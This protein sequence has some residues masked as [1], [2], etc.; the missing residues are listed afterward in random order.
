[1]NASTVKILQSALNIMKTADVRPGNNVILLGDTYSDPVIIEALQNAAFS[2]D[3]EVSVVSGTE[4]PH[5]G[6]AFGKSFMNSP[7][8]PILDALRSADLIVELHPVMSV[9]WRPFFRAIGEAKGRAT[10]TVLQFGDRELMS[11]ELCTYPIELI[12]TIVRKVREF[13]R[14]GGTVRVTTPAGTD[15]TANYED[16]M[17]GG[18]MSNGDPTPGPLLPGQTV[19][20]PH[21]VCGFV[22]SPVSGKAVCE[23]FRGFAGDLKEPIVLT[24]DKG[25]VLN[26]DGGD[27]AKFLR[28]K[29]GL[30]KARCGHFLFGINPKASLARDRDEPSHREAERSPACIDIHADGEG[31]DRSPGYL[32]FPTVTVNGKTLIDHGRLKVLDDSEIKSVAGKYGDPNRLLEPVV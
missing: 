23:R 10:K 5:Y 11:S 17:L 19:S 6:D 14:G 25:I 12:Y 3:C 22:N 8:R 24:Y 21:G 9:T 20:F 27:E 29:L 31:V 18:M 28:E 13:L 2:F 30:G 1:M 15:L 26:I 7:P 32:L 4:F 16:K